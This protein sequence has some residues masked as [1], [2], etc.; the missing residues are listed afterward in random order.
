[1]HTHPSGPPRWVWIVYAALFGASVPWYLPRGLGPIWFG[2]PYWVVISIAAI[3]SVSAFTLLVVR[4]Y[5][6]DDD[7]PTA[8]VTEDPR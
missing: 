8:T 3:A 5:W 7:Q 6:P 1:M 4:R 2:L